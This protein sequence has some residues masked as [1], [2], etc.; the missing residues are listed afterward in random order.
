MP[1]LAALGEWLDRI[2]AAAEA[3]HAD[4]GRGFEGGACAVDVDARHQRV[5]G[6]REGDPVDDHELAGVAGHVEPLPQG[7]SAEQA[8]VRVAHELLGQLGKLRLPLRQRGRVGQPLAMGSAFPRRWQPAQVDT[9]E[10]T[11]ACSGENTDV[12]HCAN[13]RSRAS[14][15]GKTTS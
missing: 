8:G 7:E 1:D 4:R 10:G 3:T 12:C 15:D 9:A 2:A 11:G 13:V 6:A 5:V 14:P